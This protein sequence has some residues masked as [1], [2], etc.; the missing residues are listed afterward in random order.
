M[1]AGLWEFPNADGRLTEESVLALASGWE[2][3]PRRA[4]PF[5]RAKH[6][7]THVEWHMN[8]FLVD[9]DSESPFFL[10]KTPEEISR[11][12]SLPTAF[13]AFQKK[14]GGV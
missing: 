4:E 3:A 11:D 6:I 1:L 12:Y 10:W 9:C 13:R 5:G 7:F 8:G 14:I 2:A